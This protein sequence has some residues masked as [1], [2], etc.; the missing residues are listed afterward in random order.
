MAK[1]IAI[2][3]T[4]DTKGPEFAFLKAE[5]EKRGC[6]TLV[7]NVGVLGTPMFQPEISAEE[8]AAAGGMKLAD[9]V[10]RHDR[11]HAM[12]V[13]N[14]GAA[15]VVKKLFGE[16]RFDGIISMGGGGGTGVAASAMRALAGRRSQAVGIDSGVGG[17]QPLCRH[18]RHLYDAVDCRRGRFESHQ[19]DHLHQCC[20]CHLRHGNG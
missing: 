20:R 7:I 2:I 19:P 13:M 4:L 11:G 12:E 5:I 14:R 18:D 10:A 1:T 17:Y 15:V 8:V 16:G 6:R 3:G 9:L